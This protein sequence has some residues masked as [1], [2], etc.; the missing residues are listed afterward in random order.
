MP[1]YSRPGRSSAVAALTFSLCAASALA[2]GEENN[3]ARVGLRS[4]LP[5]GGGNTQLSQTSGPAFG[6]PPALG[7]GDTG[8][9]SAEQ[10]QYRLKHR[11][12]KKPAMAVAEIQ[13]RA[14]PIQAR[15]QRTNLAAGNITA[16][17]P[18][19]AGPWKRSKAE[20][21]PYDPVGVRAGAFVLKPSIEIS[22]G[23]DDNP[24]RVQGGAGSLFTTVKS[25]L[26]ATS[27]WSR[28]EMSIDLRGSFTHYSDIDHNDRPDA[29]AVVRGRID[30][31]KTTRIELEEK[32]AL[33]TQ[34]AGTPDSINGAKRPPN[35]YTLGSTVG[36]VQ[37][38]NRFELGLYGGFERNIYQNADLLGG[39]VLDLSDSN[40]NSYSA[41]LRGSYEVTGG[42]KP[43]AEVSVDTRVFDHTVDALGI[44]RGSDGMKADVGITLDRPEI[45]K[46]EASIG[47]GRRNYDDP[48]LQ[49]ISGLMVDASLVWKAT[50]LT[51]VTF[52][53]TSTIGE[54]TLTGASGVFT[55]E[56]KVT[57][58]HAFRRWLVGSAFGSYGVDDYQGIGQIDKR[59]TYGGALTYYFN[60]TLGLRGEVRQERLTSNVPGQD[61][62]ANIALIGARL[63]R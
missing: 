38:F 44:R 2:A 45:I 8:F 12:K 33:T 59:F 20:E 16:G 26:T 35:I 41:R 63:Q 60:R 29:A 1:R 13:T 27:D 49:N 47:Y 3:S 4:T 25:A 37:A 34:S 53:V 48:T 42:V 58:D 6:S 56:A 17:I 19:T 18:S 39:G 61:Y 9:V 14:A 30:V 24:L 22:E 36:V 7:A 21:E 50:P 11:K 10:A 52:A 40:Y 32:A 28:H 57:V 54:S 51:K 62:T 46:G 31:T 43:F 55:R 23:Y 5:A 15:A